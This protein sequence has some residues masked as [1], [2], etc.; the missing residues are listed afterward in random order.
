MFQK[1]KILEIFKSLNL[2]SFK[3][4][5][6]SMQVSKLV[7]FHS[8]GDDYC[9]LLECEGLG[10]SIGNTPANGFVFAWRDDVE[11][12]SNPG[13]KRIYAIKKDVATGLIAVQNEIYLKN[14]GTIEVT[15]G[16]DLKIVVNGNADIKAQKVNIDA[17][18]TSI[19]VGGKKIARLGDEVTVTVPTH[20]DC[21][22]TITSA[23]VNT[24]I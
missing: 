16:K 10:G 15:G 19:G 23:G 20:G 4:K 2:R 6:L 24:S 9:P 11:R 22:G 13:E 12:K 17:T 21:K 14:D 8:G 18:Q 7:Q 1:I 3:T 5:L